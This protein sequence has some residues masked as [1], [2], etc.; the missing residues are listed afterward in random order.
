MGEKGD[1]SEKGRRKILRGFSKD[2]A[3]QVE[4]SEFFLLRLNLFL[5]TAALDCEFYS[6]GAD[7]RNSACK[8]TPPVFTRGEMLDWG[9]RGSSVKKRGTAKISQEC[10]CTWGGG[11]SAQKTRK[12]SQILRETS[13]KINIKA[14][15]ASKHGLINRGGNKINHI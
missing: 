3:C 5:S 14:K 9:T 15:H 2:L 8:S 4:V 11:E 13:K 12:V 1:V 6:S 7:S 10:F